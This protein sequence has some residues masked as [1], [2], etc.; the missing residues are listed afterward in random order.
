M[1]EKLTLYGRQF[2]KRNLNRL[3]LITDIIWDLPRKRAISILKLSAREE[4]KITNMRLSQ[5][6][7][8]GGIVY[9]LVI[10]E[11]KAAQES[12]YRWVDRC[13]KPTSIYNLV[14]NK[15]PLV[16]G[17]VKTLGEFIGHVCKDHINL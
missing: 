6:Q 2:G 8:T 13:N 3:R 4:D 17:Q 11:V 14:A 1:T 12:T 7:E 5:E 9:T 15:K 10:E 16:L